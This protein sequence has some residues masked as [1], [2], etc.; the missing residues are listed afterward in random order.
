MRINMK[1]RPV[2]NEHYFRNIV[3]SR[4]KWTCQKCGSVEYPQAHHR[5]F[6]AETSPFN[7][8]EEAMFGCLIYV[9]IA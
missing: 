7:G 9:I 3:R 2:E 1:K 6:A 4:D 8:G 5:I